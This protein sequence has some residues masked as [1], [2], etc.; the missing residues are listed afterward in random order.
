MSDEISV[1]DNF[2]LSYTVD[3]RERRI[4]F[5]TAYLDGE[6]NEY[7]DIIFSGVTAYHFER[8]NLGSILFDVEKV[9]PE[10]VYADYCDVFERNKN[11]GWLKIRYDTEVELMAAL[12]AQAVKGFLIWSSY[13]MTGFVLAQ[14]MRLLPL[15]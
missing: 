9:S 4:T 8:D 1:H 10:R 12:K 13:G 5:R 2:V 3:C 7:T 6:K 11:Y 15:S 14:E